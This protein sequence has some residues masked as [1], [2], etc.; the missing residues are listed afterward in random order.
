MPGQATN[1]VELM[2]EDTRNTDFENDWKLLTLFIGGNDL[3]A[4]C[5]S[6]VTTK[7]KMF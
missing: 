4:Y 7:Y 6:P 5:N 3:C 1:L 2:K